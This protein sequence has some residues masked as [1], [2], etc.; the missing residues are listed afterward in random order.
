[1]S[2]LPL[3]PLQNSIS[4]TD[5]EAELKELLISVYAA[6]IDAMADEINCYGAPHL[7]SFSLIER[8]VTA[9]GLALIRQGDESGMRY[10]F[11]AWRHLNPQRG[12]HFLKT[13]L[14]VLWGDAH[15]VSQ[16][17]QKT[18]EP[19]PTA[20]KSQ[21][22]VEWSGEALEDYFLTSRV[23]V[24]LDTD[25]V[26]DRIVRSLRTAVAARFVLKVRISKFS[27]N[28]FN[29]GCCAYAYQIGKFKGTVKDLP[30]RM[31]TRLSAGSSAYAVQLVRF[32]GQAE[33]T[34]SA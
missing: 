21:S 6:N 2:D 17:W 20:L 25:I 24:D 16:M 14:Q 13:Y 19:Y 32:R 34:G 11:R 29:T 33:F 26:P 12:L 4:A 3:K 31:I 15:Q 8:L 5:I 7:G 1:M 10:L 22:E 23:T 18:S 30:P 9:D 27:V 28:A